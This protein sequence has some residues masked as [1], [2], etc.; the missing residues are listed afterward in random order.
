MILKTVK[1]WPRF[2]TRLATDAQARQTPREA[3]IQG[4]LPFS[5]TLRKDQKQSFG[6]G[7]ASYDR[8]H[9]SALRVGASKKGGRLA[10]FL[11]DGSGF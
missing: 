10:P 2:P 9:Q 7:V 6:D 3:L 4:L 1:I 11:W 5:A 8:P